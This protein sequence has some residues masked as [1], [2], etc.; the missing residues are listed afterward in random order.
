MG[1]VAARLGM[2]RQED[3]P[4]LATIQ[5]AVKTILSPV[6]AMRVVMEAATV[7]K[8]GLGI[9]PPGR[10]VIGPQI[11]RHWISVVL[12]M[13]NRRATVSARPR[14]HHNT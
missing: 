12:T 2:G 3:G 11:F 10:M 8:T 9:W 6:G 1:V 14:P 7:L 5:V 4:R 13:P